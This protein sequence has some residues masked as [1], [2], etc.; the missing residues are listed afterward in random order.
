MGKRI[1]LVVIVLLLVVGFGGCNSYNSLVEMEE[2]VEGL[3]FACTVPGHYTPM[4]GDF[5]IQG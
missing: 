5:V 4:H 3:Q 2:G 1:L